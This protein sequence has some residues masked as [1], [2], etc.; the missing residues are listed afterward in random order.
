MIYSQ[1]WNFCLWGCIGRWF[2]G[3]GLWVRGDGMEDWILGDGGD[4]LLL[5]DRAWNTIYLEGM[6][7]FYI[8]WVLIF[9]KLKES[10]DMNEV[11]I[12]HS[13]L[14]VIQLKSVFAW[15]WWRLCLLYL[16]FLFFSIAMQ[17]FQ[18]R[19][20]IV[21]SKKQEEIFTSFAE[22]NFLNY[23]TTSIQ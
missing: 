22:Y 19:I 23:W 21:Y 15:W 10:K 8:I 3:G 1:I 12:E 13:N 4:L 16:L 5:V 14:T 18:G 17:K 20:L 7:V 9:N 6:L 11:Y 2:C